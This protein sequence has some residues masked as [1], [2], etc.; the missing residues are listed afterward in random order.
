MAASIPACRDRHCP[1]CGGEARQRWLEARRDEVL[2]VPYFHVV[3]TIPE[4]LNFLAL[5]APEVVY[6]ILLRAA[7]QALLDLGASRL[8]A[9]I[10]RAHRA[11]H[12][13]S[14]SRL[15]S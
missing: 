6:A 7:G 5:Y 2:D 9:R 12:L 8:R 11:S 10:G 1:Q 15:P 14:D 13:G 4:I 3:Y